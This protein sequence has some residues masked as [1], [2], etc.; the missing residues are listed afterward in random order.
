[1]G[2]LEKLILLAVLFVAAI[3]LAFSLN[4]SKVEGAGSGPLDAAQATLDETAGTQTALDEAS[5]GSGANRA[6]V[7]PGLLLHAGG[8]GVESATTRSSL[9]DA[10]SADETPSAPVSSVVEAADA[11]ILKSAAGLEASILDEY[12]VYTVADGD[13]WAGLAQRFYQDGRF[14]RN[15]HL[16]NEDLVELEPGTEILVPIYDFLQ[17]AGIRPG[18]PETASADASEPAPIAA[19]RLDAGEVGR[20]ANGPSGLGGKGE[21]L[22]QEYVVQ[23]GDNLSG[24]SLA[25]YGTGS[26]WKEIFD[27]NRDKLESPDWL[28][29]GMKLKI[30]GGFSPVKL[31]AVKPSSSS[32]PS[33]KTVKKTAPEPK[34]SSGKPKKK[35]Q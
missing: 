12:M 18:L 35:V 16:A 6:A 9:A 7:E 33:T 14:T 24:I 2:N 34:A 32:S 27:A 31:A 23:D 29:V 30:P 20:T 19:A 21:A 1:M 25:V 3:V 11:R 4:R 17:E 15:L 8:S 22:V 5:P 10:P 26:R 28:Q 13:T